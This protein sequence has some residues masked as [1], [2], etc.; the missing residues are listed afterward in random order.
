MTLTIM[1]HEGRNLLQYSQKSRNDKQSPYNGSR[2]GYR[3]SFEDHGD[4]PRNTRSTD[5]DNSNNC[6]NL[7]KCIPPP[8]NCKN[9]IPYLRFLRFSRTSGIWGAWCKVNYHTVRWH[10]SIRTT[11]RGTQDK[12]PGASYLG[13]QLTIK[14]GTT[15]SSV[16][17]YTKA[18]RSHTYD[19]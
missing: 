16:Q 7:F 2:N 13:R 3:K 18:L 14:Q 5:D 9:T 10:R 15:T 19:L 17:F 4:P 11:P 12:Q 1:L 6:L 8:S